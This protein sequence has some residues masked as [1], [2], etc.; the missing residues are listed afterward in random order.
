M[1][2][3]KVLIY[4][5]ET[6]PLL[7]YTWG[8]W[9]QNVAL[10]QIKN[11]WYVLSWSAKWLGEKK[12]MYADQRA[13]KNIE[14]DK[15][16][17]EKIWK[18]LDEADIV[19]TQN[20]KKFDQKKLNA[21]FIIHNMK[22]P[23]PYRHLDTL[24]M[25]RRHFGFTSNKLEY[26]SEKLCTK[27]KKLTK[28]KEYSGFELWKACIAGDLKAW[29]AM[30]LYNKQDVLSL[31]ELYQKLAPWA[32]QMNFN[33]YH[34]E[35]TNECDCGKTS[36]IKKGFRYTNSGKFQN[37]QCTSCGAQTRGKTNLLSKEKRQ[38]LRSKS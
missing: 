23:S 22:P 11:D 17:L 36:I 32:N 19:I 9:D 16:L 20:G 29:K 1:Q 6:A 15:A 27:F 12:V 35:L 28:R 5:I 18:L 7:S 30:E 34:E 25:A 13:A 14:N 37:Y 38:S 2:K 31:E 8:L 26:L 21:R 10:N 4:D 24:E 3:P 33:V